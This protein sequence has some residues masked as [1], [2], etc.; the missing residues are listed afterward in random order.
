M[1]IRAYIHLNEN[2][3]ALRNPNRFKTGTGPART[4]Y[5]QKPNRFEKPNRIQNTNRSGAERF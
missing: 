1:Y 2:R 3:T 4:G 5:K